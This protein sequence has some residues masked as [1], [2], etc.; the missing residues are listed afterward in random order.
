LSLIVKGGRGHDDAWRHHDECL[1]APSIQR[2]V[3]DEL[4]IDDGAHDTI[5][6]VDVYAWRLH[7]NRVADRPH[8]EVEVLFQMIE[9]IERD[10]RN[11]DQFECALFHFDL[12][13]ARTY[14]RKQIP[15]TAVR[16][17]R[18][19][20]PAVEIDETNGGPGNDGAGWISDRPANACRICLAVCGRRPSDRNEAGQRG[21]REAAAP[22]PME[23]VSHLGLGAPHGHP[24]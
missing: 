20:D 16:D 24:H 8:L 7:P 1:D 4:A 21:P 6:G 9:D 10:R 15:A 5:R 11:T 22:T 18:G 3:V 19:F 17:H 12:V 13:V 2:N 14:T 23:H